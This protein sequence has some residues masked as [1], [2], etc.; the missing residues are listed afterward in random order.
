MRVS[1]LGFGLVA[2]SVT[3]SV[4]GVPPTTQSPEDPTNPTDPMDP[5]DPKDPTDC[6]LIEQFADVDRDGFGDPSDRVEDCDILPGRVTN[7]EDCRDDDPNIYPGA[8]ER[9]NAIDDDC[10]PTTPGEGVGF[11]DITGWSD[12]TASFAAG[13]AMVPTT[14]SLLNDGTLHVCAGRWFVGLDIQA[15]VNVVGDPSGGAVVL[16]GEDIISGILV[17]DGASVTLEDL[18]LEEFMGGSYGASLGSALGCGNGSTVVARNVEFFDNESLVGGAVWARSGCDLTLENTTFRDN[19]S[20]FGGGHLAVQG[21]TAVVDDSSF[22]GGITLSEGGAILVVAGGGNAASLTCTDCELDAN[23]AGTDGGGIAVLGPDANVVMTGGEIT[24]SVAGNL[25]GG[26]Y[27]FTAGNQ[28]TTSIS[29]SNTSF[30]PNVT[31][32]DESDV[33]YFANEFFNLNYTYSGVTTVFC[34]QYGCI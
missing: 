6:P 28:V 32:G 24:D 21:S 16:D 4:P 14:E 31:Q 34:N 8:P 17:D 1:L 23:E 29:F 30:G 22:G 10:N 12:L 18:R 25:G 15:N 3:P 13:T 5:T 9:C 19:Q 7:G 2:C 26:V 33:Y 20:A 11:E 27:L